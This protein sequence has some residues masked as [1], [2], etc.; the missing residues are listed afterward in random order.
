MTHGI[1]CVGKGAHK[2]SE[3]ESQAASVG[4]SRGR[5][6]SEGQAGDAGARQRGFLCFALVCVVKGRC[7]RMSSALDE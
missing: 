3:G 5:R 4:R 1:L 7:V 6:Y 2:S